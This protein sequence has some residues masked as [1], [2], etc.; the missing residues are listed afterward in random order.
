LNSHET[1]NHKSQEN[2]KGNQELKVNEAGLLS[3]YARP[4]VCLLALRCKRKE[5]QKRLNFGKGHMN[6]HGSN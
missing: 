2:T 3:S 1:G 5:K 6:G 4:R